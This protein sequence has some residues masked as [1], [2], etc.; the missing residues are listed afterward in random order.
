MA[1]G[2]NPLKRFDVKLIKPLVAAFIASGLLTSPALADRKHGDRGR[3]QDRAFQATREGRSMPLPQIERRVMPFMGGAD[4][5]G[6][7][8]NGQT[9]R[10]KFV[11][12]GRVIWVDVDAATGRILGRSG[13]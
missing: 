3:D 4:Y 8:F 7:E 10:L 9:Y 13:N 2:I 1:C 5:L 11:R 6:P 12:G